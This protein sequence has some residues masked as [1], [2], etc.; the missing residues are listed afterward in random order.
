MPAEGDRIA[1]EKRILG[2]AIGV[3]GHQFSAIGDAVDVDGSVRIRTP[4]KK[5]LV[6]IG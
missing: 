5:T 2:S 3:T 1:H 6:F 4:D